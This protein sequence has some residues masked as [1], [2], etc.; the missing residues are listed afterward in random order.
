MGLIAL[1]YESQRLDSWYCIDFAFLFIFFNTC[2]S[3]RSLAVN[4]NLLAYSLVRDRHFTML[5]FAEP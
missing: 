2:F 1:L 4:A 5:V 3:E